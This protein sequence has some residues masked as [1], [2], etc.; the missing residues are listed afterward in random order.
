MGK[1]YFWKAAIKPGRPFAIGKIKDTIIICLPG[2]PVSVHLL[3]GMI[4]RPFIEYLCSGKFLIPEN[5]IAK[6]DF[7]MKKKI[8]VLNGLESMLIRRKI[9]WLWAN[10][11]NKVLA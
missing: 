2:N 11:L 3:Y 8:S 7:V 5:L 1:V 4:V 6:T 9:I 10:F